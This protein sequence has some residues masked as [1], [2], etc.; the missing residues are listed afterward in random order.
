MRV[1]ASAPALTNP[2][3][4]VTG[5]AGAHTIGRRGSEQSTFASV[6]TT[7]NDM[8]PP[9]QEG[10]PFDPEAMDAK[11]GLNEWGAFGGTSGGCASTATAASGPFGFGP[12]LFHNNSSGGDSVSGSSDG[13]KMGC[14]D[15]FE[16]DQLLLRDPLS[17]NPLQAVSWAKL[18]DG[19]A[20]EE[21]DGEEA[22]RESTPMDMHAE[23]SPER[24]MPGE[25]SGFS[26]ITHHGGGP[27]SERAT[28]PVLRQQQQQQRQRES[29]Y[30]RGKT[31]LSSIGTVS[32]TLSAVKLASKTPEPTGM[33]N[34]SSAVVPAVSVQPTVRVVVSEQKTSHGSAAASRHQNRERRQRHRQSRETKKH[35]DAPHTAVAT[36]PVSQ[37]SYQAGQ[38]YQQQEYAF[39][40]PPL[41]PPFLP[42]YHQ[43]PPGVYSTEMQYQQQAPHPPL[44]AYGNHESYAP[45]P[46][47]EHQP[48]LLCLAP[49]CNARFRCEPELNAHYSIEHSFMCNW[50]SC[51]S[52]NFTSQNAL[53]W[54]VKAEHLLVCPVP[55][56]CGQVFASK[57]ALDGHVRVN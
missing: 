40:S 39:P 26:H 35:G 24:A 44:I 10:Q 14:G 36:V 28:R 42:P 15:P 3:N 11:K 13:E 53:V 56:C 55:G 30:G 23:C 48:L 8:I 18:D 2:R 38:Y 43:H 27:E 17:F 19:E 12:L 46:P 32:E 7:S 22:G 21:E 25:T 54:H 31:D 9:G 33:Y 1:S 41:P 16:M 50:A 29:P 34:S 51:K 5:N 45:P 52:A 20:M 37:L 4:H 49:S 57:K 6:P 47:P